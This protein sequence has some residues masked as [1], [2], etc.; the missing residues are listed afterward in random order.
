MDMYIYIHRLLFIWYIYFDN[1]NIKRKSPFN[2]LQ[3]ES[4]T[5][6][7]SL[8]KLWAKQKLAIIII[9]KPTYSNKQGINEVSDP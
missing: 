7:I 8:I 5:I 4:E 3:K 9:N 1:K 2:S 6:A